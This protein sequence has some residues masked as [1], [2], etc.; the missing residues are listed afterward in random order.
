M[1][2]GLLETSHKYSNVFYTYFFKQFDQPGPIRTGGP[3]TIHCPHIKQMSLPSR[4]NR[5]RSDTAIELS[6]G[7]QYH[8]RVPLYV[9]LYT[10][11]PQEDGTFQ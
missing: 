3:E 1:N 8:I 4:V 9:P 7:H 2:N 11:E 10:C 5:L 6:I